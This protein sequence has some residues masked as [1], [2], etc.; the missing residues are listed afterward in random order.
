MCVGMCVCRCV[1]VGT[2]YVCV[3]CVCVCV[4]IVNVR[5]TVNDVQ[6]ALLMISRFS[7]SMIQQLKDRIC[8]IAATFVR[9]PCQL[10][11]CN[12]ATLHFI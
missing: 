1:C 11:V 8:S 12:C 10:H 5:T 2:M 4:S 9:L 7:F 6:S 3:G